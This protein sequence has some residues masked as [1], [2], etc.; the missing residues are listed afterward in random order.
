MKARG[1]ALWVLVASSLAACAS[2]PRPPRAPV[3]E[4]AIVHAEDTRPQNL[5][6]QNA[7]LRE[8]G[9]GT[10]IELLPPRRAPLVHATIAGDPVL[11]LVDSGASAHVIT[12]DVARKLELASQATSNQFF[13]AG[14]R[15]QAARRTDAAQVTI[16]RWGRLPSGPLF[17]VPG[18]EANGAATTGISGLL[19]PQSLDP[20]HTIVLD[21]QREELRTVDDEMAAD[22]FVFGAHDL[23]DTRPC[24][25]LYYI[26]ALIEGEPVRVLV[27]TGADSTIIY[28]RTAAGHRLRLR[29]MQNNNDQVHGV[30][31]AIAADVLLDV[32]FRLGGL[33]QTR[34]ITIIEAP[35][36]GCGGEGILGLDVLRNC[37]LIFGSGAPPRTLHVRCK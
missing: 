36:D 17:I 23:G 15:K 29:R 33:N 35:G 21:L 7:R 37:A 8:G 28:G 18:D 12:G 27:D 4:E 6:A 34:N 9:R 14:G 3:A 10:N 24:G 20:R 11:L 1:T 26:T 31:G 25:N 19:S 16:D 30:A 5:K 13:D 2:K 22:P 32:R